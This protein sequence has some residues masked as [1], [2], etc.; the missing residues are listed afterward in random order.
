M[1][2]V[3]PGGVAE[4]GTRTG[5]ESFDCLFMSLVF[6]NLPSCLPWLASG[7]VPD[8]QR[9][10]EGSESSAER[11]KSLHAAEVSLFISIELPNIPPLT[12]LLPFRSPRFSTLRFD[13]PCEP[14]HRPPIAFSADLW[15]S[16]GR[17]MRSGVR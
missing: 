3:S 11:I 14:P 15:S 13:S 7:L 1:S 17:L 10:Y 6:P 9:Y 5:K 2:G 8:G 16:S 12:T 4:N